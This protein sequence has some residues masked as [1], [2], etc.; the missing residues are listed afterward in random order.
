[1][2]K[3]MMAALVL[4]AGPALAQGYVAPIPGTIV[5]G[6]TPVPGPHRSMS[7][8]RSMTRAE[9]TARVQR[10]FAALDMNHDGAIER[11][12]LPAANRQQGMA[13]PPRM[14]PPGGRQGQMM[15]RN[16]EWMFAA[17][18]ANGDGRV[19]MQ[20]ANALAL[21]HFDMMDRNHD[22]QITPDEHRPMHG[23]MRQPL[24]VR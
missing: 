14:M 4:A 20:E 24:I 13:H 11:S 22:G 1:M 23:R 18:D 7:P 6:V 17:A 10:L 8:G 2:K 12:E 5:P 21:R 19:T 9:V 16:G 3:I 15:M